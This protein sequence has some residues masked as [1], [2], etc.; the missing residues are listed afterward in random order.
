MSMSKESNDIFWTQEVGKLNV[1]G[2]N[3]LTVSGD[4][5][6]YSGLSDIAIT[7]AGTL[8]N[9][10]GT[11]NSRFYGH[12]YVQSSN[13]DNEKI[14]ELVINCFYDAGFNIISESESKRDYSKKPDIFG[15]I[16]Y[17]FIKSTDGFKSI[18]YLERDSIGDLITSSGELI[19]ESDES[20]FFEKFRLKI[21]MDEG[22]I[23]ISNDSEF[24][25]L[26]E[27]AE[28]IIQIIEGIFIDIRKV[29]FGQNISTVFPVSDSDTSLCID[30]AGKLWSGPRPLIY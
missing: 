7:P 29:T 22:Y 16:G 24:Y 2:T 11:I 28:K 8:Y 25:L 5:N 3:D 21:I 20:V 15:W 27:E 6:N 10:I 23:F 13:I 18:L 1:V 19:L 12:D 14:K 9:T 30:N 17:G 4:I 26:E